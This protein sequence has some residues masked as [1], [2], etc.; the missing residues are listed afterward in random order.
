MK[1]ICGFT[2]TLYVT[3]WPNF[4]FYRGYWP[5]KTHKLSRHQLFII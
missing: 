2:F 3:F 1:I 5:H 4:G